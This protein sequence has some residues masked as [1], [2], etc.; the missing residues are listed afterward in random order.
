MK[1]YYTNLNSK[2]IV[3]KLP[4]QSF[5][6]PEYPALHVHVKLPI[7]SMQCALV[8]QL[9]VPLLHSLISGANV[10]MQPKLRLVQ[11]MTQASLHL[12]IESSTHRM[13]ASYSEL[14]LSITV[15]ALF[16]G[17]TA[18]RDST[19]FIAKSAD[20]EKASI[21]I[22]TISIGV[23]VV[24]AKFTFIDV[25][26]SA[27]KRSSFFYAVLKHNSIWIITNQLVVDCTSWKVDYATKKGITAV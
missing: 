6:S 12:S 9:W 5:P 17:L 8:G 4:M 27:G 10:S 20:A 21:S 16:Y 14:T 22:H 7:V 11:N 18:A 3:V 13:L 24:C 15:S 23:T 1:L 2:Q 26:S 19:P 25:A